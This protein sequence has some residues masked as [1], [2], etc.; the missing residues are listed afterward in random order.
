MKAIVRSEYGPPHVLRLEDIPKPAPDSN[1]VLV[2]VRSSSVGMADVDYMLGR[3]WLARLGTGPRRPRDTGLDVA[4]EVGAVGENVTRFQLGDE[5]FGDMTQHGFGAFA[6]YVCA[7][8]SAFSHKPPSLSFVQA[9]AMP[10]SAIMALQGLRG[11]RKIESGQRVLINGAGG[12]I[13]PFAVQIAKAFGAE[14]TGVDT[15]TKL[16]MLRSIGADHVIDYTTTDYTRSGHQYDWILDIA[17][18]HSIFAS[19]RALR[20]GGTYIMVPAT[21]PHMFQGMVLGPLLS[22][23]TK[24]K[25]VMMAWKPFKLEDVDT[26]KELVAEGKLTPVIDREYALSDVAAALRYQ[27]EG[28]PKGKIIINI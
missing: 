14:V 16:E 8:E 5:V 3:P 25:M 23:G 6:E 15:T 19:R 11:G 22:I 24:R 27:A 17:P 20:A 4:G 1:G 9:A 2:R 13:G 21:M 12:N 18:F 28:L 10:Q 7:P 26:L